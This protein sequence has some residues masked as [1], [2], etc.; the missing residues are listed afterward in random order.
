MS[1]YDLKPDAL[2][3]IQ[4]LE[5]E[6]HQLLT[7]CE[8]LERERDALL[9]IIRCESTFYNPMPLPCRCCKNN[10]GNFTKEKCRWCGTV[11]ACNNF[12]WRGVKED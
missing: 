11:D 3:Y 4:Q 12:E 8:R 7:R 10:D 5:T 2:T 1:N 6:R 9:D